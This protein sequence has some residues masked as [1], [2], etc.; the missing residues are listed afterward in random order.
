MRAAPD[1][2]RCIVRE[3]VDAAI[4]VRM[5]TL[6]P[7]RGFIASMPGAHIDVQVALGGVLRSRSYSVVE[8]RDRGWT[9]AVRRLENGRG[10]SLLM[11]GLQAGDVVMATPPSSH[12][13][14]SPSGPDY[15]LIAGGIGVTPLVGMARRL[16]PRSKVRML[17]AG[18]SR[19]HMAFMGTL[20][21]LLGDRL[22]VYADDE[23][24]M[25]NLAREFAALHPEGE[26]YLCGP[27]G[28]LAAARTAW[29]DAG[30]PEALLRFETFGTGGGADPEPFR[31]HVRDHGITLDVARDASLLDALAAAGIEVAH[32]CLRGE[33]GLCAVDVV[34][35]AEIDHR[36]V[37]LSDEQRRESAKLCIC[38]S[39]ASGEITVDTGF[40]AGLVRAG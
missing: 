19:A 1:W 8:D 31:V 39:R 11:C 20:G 3:A 22:S 26:A 35:E 24:R 33:C 4:G 10:G 12:F 2:V 18:R 38:V 9:I 40:R 17:Y 16:A 6:V 28:M 37:F 27:A 5:I 25:I 36:C 23:G 30:R 15:L 34:G 14:L 7:E 29:R 13:D 32:D 21:S